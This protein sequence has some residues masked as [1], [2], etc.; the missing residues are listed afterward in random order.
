[1]S[2]ISKKPF[3]LSPTVRAILG[4]GGPSKIVRRLGGKVHVRTVEFW[5]RRARTPVGYLKQ[6]SAISGI[7]VDEFLTYEETMLHNNLESLSLE[8]DHLD[9]NAAKNKSVKRARG[10]PRTIE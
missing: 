10:R 3:A 4:A 8:S 6:M 9:D 5:L 1:M 2:L 7:P